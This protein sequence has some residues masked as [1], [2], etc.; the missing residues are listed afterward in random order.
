MGVGPKGLTVTARFA[1]LLM[2]LLIDLG[3]GEEHIEA[4]SC[5][6]T[7]GCWARHWASLTLGPQNGDTAERMSKL[8][9][10]DTRMCRAHHRQ[11]QMIHANGKKRA[12]SSILLKG[13]S[14]RA[15]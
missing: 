12:G 15:N 4:P 7:A 1:H 14:W 8:M 9:S 2:P 3:G 10:A 6:E 11:R 5:L 13:M